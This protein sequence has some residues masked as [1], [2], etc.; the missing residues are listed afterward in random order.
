MSL[1]MYHHHFPWQKV[2][3]VWCALKIG[4]WDAGQ[5]SWGWGGHSS[6]A[7][8]C[9]LSFLSLLPHH[10]TTHIPTMGYRL[11]VPR[12]SSGDKVKSS[13]FLPSKIWGPP[14]LCAKHFARC[15]VKV[16]RH[17][18]LFEDGHKRFMKV[19]SKSLA[20]VCLEMECWSPFKPPE[21]L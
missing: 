14:H 13:L 10:P 5:V 21:C 11:S 15:Y 12:H 7:S 1:H 2:E 3:K 8:N 20:W 4:T 18:A 9:E 16:L 17:G 6:E 19:L